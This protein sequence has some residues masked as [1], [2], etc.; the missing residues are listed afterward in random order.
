MFSSAEKLLQ[1]NYLQQLRYP[2]PSKLPQK[3]IFMASEERHDATVLC[4]SSNS[5][6]P[7]KILFVSGNMGTFDMYYSFTSS[8]AHSEITW[9]ML[10]G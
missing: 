3:I 10:I 6:F 1:P 5:I 9:V 8:T 4:L 2:Q 7:D